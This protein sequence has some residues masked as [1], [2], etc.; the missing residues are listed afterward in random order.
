MNMPEEDKDNLPEIVAETQAAEPQSSTAP[1]KQPPLFHNRD[2]MLLWS[3]QV[4]S[5]LGSGMSGLVFPLLILSISGDNKALAGFAQALGSLPYL[6]FSLPVGALIDR[7]DRK[8]VMMI[9]DAFRALNFATIPIALYFDSLTVW[10]LLANAFISA[11][12]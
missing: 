4:V 2:Y 9:C 6:L 12:R 11:P 8:R 10:Q 5:A 7:W 1:E 3:G